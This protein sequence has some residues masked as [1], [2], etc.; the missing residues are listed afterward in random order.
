VHKDSLFETEDLHSAINM[1]MVVSSIVAIGSTAQKNNYEGPQFGP[2]Y[3][4]KNVRDFDDEVIQEGNRVIGLQ[5]GY[6]LG[7]S[8]S[9][10]T[11]YGQPRQIYDPKTV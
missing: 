5:M 9:G 1:N 11:P 10:M 2:R 8:Q 7:A 6:N 4:D 3:A